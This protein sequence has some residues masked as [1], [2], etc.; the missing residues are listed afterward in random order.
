MTGE[1][2]AADFRALGCDVRVAVTDPAVVGDAYA[3]LDRRLR[4][5][6][7]ACSRFRPDSELVRLADTAGRPVVVSP[8]LTRALAAGLRG[9]QLTGGAVDPTLGS[10]MA[11]AGYDR[12]YGTVQLTLTRR[13]SG[14]WT[15]GRRADAGPPAWRRVRLDVERQTVTVPPEV[16]FDL[17]ATAK[18]L[19]ADET[20]A[21]LATTFGCGVL[22]SLGGDVAV[23]GTAPD[24]GWRVR[25]QDRTGPVDADPD[26]PAQVVAIH[27]GA[28]ATSSTT[29]RRWV[30]H[31]H[32]V[33]H[34][35]DPRAGAPVVSRWRTASV[36]GASCLDAN[37]ASTAA[38]VRGDSSPGWLRRHGF[39]ARLVDADGTVTRV[40]GWPAEL[41]SAA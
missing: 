39:A 5:W 25:V 13:A 16:R 40:G 30:H 41:R 18:A 19:A 35:L 32:L 38:I 28:V 27:H 31:G 7:L 33:H 2:A 11:A 21:E 34:L 29:A 1:V 23:A 37:I 3:L 6:D 12:D 4:E 22:V 15:A 36:S 10:A 26:G 20:A 14:E 8:L 24:G 17:G 9:A